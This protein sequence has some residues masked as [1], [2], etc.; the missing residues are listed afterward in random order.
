MK[1]EARLEMDGNDSLETQAP[2]PES[3]FVTANDRGRSATVSALPDLDRALQE[4]ESIEVEKMLDVGCGFGGLTKLIGEHVRARESHGIDIDVNALAEAEAKGVL[5][6][7]VD[8]GTEP[9]PYR[10]SNF[11]LVVSF[12]MMDYLPT[13]DPL[14]REI[15]RVLTPTG[16]VLISLPNLGSWHNRL[17]LLFGYQPRDVE[18][19]EETVVG[20]VSRFRGDPPTG[21]IH[22]PTVRAFVELMEFHGFDTVAVTPG[23]PITR[24]TPPLLRMVDRIFARRVGLARR[25]FYVG[26]KR[27]VLAAVER[28]E[29]NGARPS[30]S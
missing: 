19:S 5:A 4:L 2:S 8:V 28:E 17:S 11:G 23:S 29:A 21:H 30:R 1:H 9:L 6:R 14:I 3:P 10:D 24:P 18:I 13:F 26:R 12:G 27:A 25:F 15:H 22:I 7:R 20:T 16:H